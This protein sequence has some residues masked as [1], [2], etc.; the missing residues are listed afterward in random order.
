MWG[1][2]RTSSLDD[3][4]YPAEVDGVYGAMPVVDISTLTEP[5]STKEVLLNYEGENK[6][7]FVLVPGLWFNTISFNLPGGKQLN[8]FD[9]WNDVKEITEDPFISSPSPLGVSIF[10]E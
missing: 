1:S 3:E 7:T 4:P 10:R 8:F 5:I 2:R 9:N 6:D